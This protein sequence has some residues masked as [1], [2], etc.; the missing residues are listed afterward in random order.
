[1]T[2]A[3]RSKVDASSAPSWTTSRAAE[4]A[5]CS[6]GSNCWNLAWSDLAA[7]GMTSAAGSRMT[8]LAAYDLVA[9]EEPRSS[10][11]FSGDPDLW[12]WRRCRFEAGDAA[13]VLEDSVIDLVTWS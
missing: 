4:V 3:R 11:S 10:K 8:P 9:A 1:M 6:Q 2:S 5:S 13:G 7:S 12:G